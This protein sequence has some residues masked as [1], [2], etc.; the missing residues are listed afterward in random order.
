MKVRWTPASTPKDPL[1]PELLLTNH[2]KSFSCNRGIWTFHNLLSP[3]GQLP[4]R[5][6]TCSRV[7]ARRKVNSVTH[8]VYMPRNALRSNVL[9][10]LSNMRRLTVGD[11]ENFPLLPSVHDSNQNWKFSSISAGTWQKR[12]PDWDTNIQFICTAEYCRV[13]LW[14]LFFKNEYEKKSDNYL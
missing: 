9:M 13:R 12:H 2:S 7:A 3:L 8:K 1:A 10:M 14:L 5:S 4:D 11:V 6:V